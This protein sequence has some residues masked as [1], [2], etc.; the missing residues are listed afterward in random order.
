MTKER[1]AGCG[2]V[3]NHL[4]LRLEILLEMAENI[5]IFEIQ[6]I[7]SRS[8]QLE[9]L[10][11]RLAHQSVSHINLYSKKFVTIN[12]GKERRYGMPSSN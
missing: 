9:E 6:Y 3:H 12:R 5:N 1:H 10:G 11:A 8:I 2:G 4:L 7:Q